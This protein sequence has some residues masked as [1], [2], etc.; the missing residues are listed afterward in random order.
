MKLVSQAI[1]AKRSKDAA[2]MAMMLAAP[3]F[4]RLQ[5]G[6]IQVISDMRLIG[7]HCLLGED[8]RYG[9]RPSVAG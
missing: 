8:G 7:Q 6:L 3:S 4:A 1:A 5:E 2:L 9:I